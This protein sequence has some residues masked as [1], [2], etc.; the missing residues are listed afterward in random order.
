MADLKWNDVNLLLIPELQ[1]V[2]DEAGEKLTDEANAELGEDGYVY[3]PPTRNLRRDRGA[4]FADTVH[5][6]YDNA[7]HHTLVKVTVRNAT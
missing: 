6:K 3:V 1:A 4:V 7:K 2:V 5:A